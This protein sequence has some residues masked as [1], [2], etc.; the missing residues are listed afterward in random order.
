MAEDVAGTPTGAQGVSLALGS[1]WSADN[2]D[3]SIW[4]RID[5]PSIPPGKYGSALEFPAANMVVGYQIDRGRT[6]ELDKTEA[7][8]ASIQVIDQY[9]LFDPT[10]TDSPY[11]TG[12]GPMVR[13]T[14]V[15]RNPV[16]GTVND[17]FT[18]YLETV[19]YKYPD[20]SRPFVNVTLSLVDGFEP[21]T[22]A[23]LVPDNTGTTVLVG[24]QV[25]D[26]MNL[27]L[28]DGQW[29]ALL[30]NLNTGNVAAQ[31]A[32]GSVYQ[33]GTSVLSALQD[34]A[35]CEFPGV[36]NVFMNKHGQVAFR[37]RF[38]RFTPDVYPNQVQQ[39]N[40]GDAIAAAASG[41]APIST[42]EW[43]VDQS[44]LFNTALCYPYGVDQ[45]LINAQLV[46]DPDSVAAYGVRAKTIN[47]LIITPGTTDMVDG[48]NGLQECLAYGQYYVDNF[49][50]PVIRISSMIFKSPDPKWIG[51]PVLGAGMLSTAWTNLW[52]LIT[53][54]EI[55][56]LVTVWTTPPT[57]GGFN[58]DTHVGDLIVGNQFFVEGT[59][60]TTQLAQADFPQIT[61]SLDLSPRIWFGTFNGTLYYPL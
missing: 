36:A 19:A 20:P 48:N 17:L 12:I 35:D 7:G 41:Y 60:Y 8:T 34:T 31:G 32:P 13:A 22:R 44:N 23:E 58:V 37:G 27:V 21:L 30:R 40:V 28:D 57:G 3:P 55:G 59:H 45:S 43:D 52:D 15:Q 5:D 26:R 18:G 33:P 51:D 49:K 47:D 42:L 16:A 2:S 14:I 53:R 38:P 46:F 54:V 39:W 11:F 1:P 4:V 56:D 24:Q 6:Y 50:L 61:L 25:Q 29:P 9:G 10:N